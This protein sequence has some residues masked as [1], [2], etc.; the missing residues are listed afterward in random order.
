MEQ[1][2]RTKVIIGLLKYL[3]AAA[4]YGVMDK[5]KTDCGSKSKGMRAAR[6]LTMLRRFYA[7]ENGVVVGFAIF[8]F[9]IILMIGGIGVDVMH[10]EMKRTK[11]QHTI[12]RAILAAADLD[13]TRDPKAVVEDY[14]DKAGMTDYLTEVLVEDGLNY[15]QVSA[16]AKTVHQTMFMKMVGVDELSVPASGVAMERIENIEISLVLDVSGS[17]NSNSRLTNLKSAAKEF[18]QTMDDNTEDGTLSISIVPY[19]TQVSAPDELFAHLNVT[20]NNEFFRYRDRNFA[21]AEPEYDDDGNLVLNLDLLNLSHVNFSNCLNFDSSD[22]ED[23][24][25]STST[26][27][28]RTMHFDPWSETDGRD[29]ASEDTYYDSSVS[30]YPVCEAKASREML[31]WSEDTTALKNY[32]DAFVADGNTSID[33]GMKWGTALLDPTLQPVVTSLIASDDLPEGFEGRPFG[34]SSGEAVKVVVLMTDG[35]NTSQYYIEEGYREGD[36]NIWWN[37]EVDV[38]SVYVGIDEYDEDNDGIT[39][40]PLFYWPGHYDKS[41]DWVDAGWYDHAYGEGVFEKTNYEYECTSWRKNGKCKKYKEVA[42][43]VEEVEEDGTAIRVTYPDLWGYTT[44]RWVADQLYA[45]WMGKDAARADWDDGVQGSNGTTTKDSRSRTIC[46][47]AKAEGITVF[48][49][50]FEAP[51]AGKAVLKDCA[52]SDGHYFD[53]GGKEISDAFASIATSIRK[54]KL[55]Q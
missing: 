18:V 19:A 44:P 10:S 15:R 36:S 2:A 26:Y 9:L 46:E 55:T 51:D 49:I 33:I 45:P 1:N 39:E 37:S 8:L 41:G 31:L 34:Y 48:T 21:E 4:G 53:V 28:E 47:A 35:Q 40:E 43:S 16:S 25:I 12:D 11:L 23:T 6:P 13:Q 3:R 27:F 50:G 32:I 30:S 14:F 54:L 17:M 22:F 20:P 42:T 7:D 29:E 38:Y 52:S 24:G 5:N